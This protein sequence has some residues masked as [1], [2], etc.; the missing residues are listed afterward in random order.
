MGDANLHLLAFLGCEPQTIRYVVCGGLVAILCV[1]LVLARTQ[2][3][4]SN[5]LRKCIVLSLVA[6]LL[7]GIY[8]TT[9]HIVS[10]GPHGGEGTT[11]ALV[12]EF[13]DDPFSSSGT[14]DAT[15]DDDGESP[16]PEAVKPAEP[17]AKA[18]PAKLAAT[19]TPS[20]AAAEP[21]A[22]P[23]LVP[24]A[25]P[26]AVAP[27]GASV[28]DVP[29]PPEAALDAPKPRDDVAD[30]GGAA[31][32]IANAAQSRDVPGPAAANITAM[33]ESGPLAPLSSRPVRPTARMPPAKC[34]KFIRCAWP[35]ITLEW[36]SNTAVAKPPRRPSGRHSNSW[37][38]INRRMAAGML[39]HWRGPSP[40]RRWPRSARGRRS[41][42]L[43]HYGPVLAV[44]SGRRAHP[45][46]RRAQ[47]GRASWPRISAQHA[48][49][50]WQSG[51]QR[52]AL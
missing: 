8:A 50:G 7:I 26:V 15:P 29:A 4:Q 37:P 22:A 1:V 6:H 25:E 5:S 35:A 18:D 38:A 51:R 10:S 9:V 46:A 41:S 17:P 52:H 39:A 34:R 42:R 45:F 3:G 32:D 28:A 30:D 16:P 11:V 33:P 40:G 13:G 24:S 19:E 23:V 20:P 44:A 49:S 2:W 14:G 21:P 48:I 43:R 27:K 31:A 47:C 12:S 36:P